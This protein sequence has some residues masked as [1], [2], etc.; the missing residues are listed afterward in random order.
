MTSYHGSRLAV[1]AII[2]A[3][4]A[5]VAT[6]ASPAYGAGRAYF[7]TT[8]ADDTVPDGFCTLREAM[9]AANNAPA[10]AD[11]GPGSLG[12]PD[13]IHFSEVGGT[14]VLGAPLPTITESLFIGGPKGVTLDGNARVHPFMINPSVDVTLERLTI[15]NGKA[16]DG[17]STN[18][19]LGE[20]GGAIHNRGALRLTDVRITHSAAGHGGS[21]LDG[22]A[23]G[24][25]GGAIYNAGTIVGYRVTFD[26]N[27]AGNGGPTVRVV[28]R[29]GHGGAI[30]NDEGGSVT[31]Y[32][33][34]FTGNAPGTSVVPGRILGFD[35]NGS[36]L[37]SRG[38]AII[39]AS[40][41]WANVNLGTGVIVPG[42]NGSVLVSSTI[43]SDHDTCQVPFGGVI[44]NG[45]FNIENTGVHCFS[46]LGAGQ[47]PLVETELRINGGFVPTLAPRGIPPI[48]GVPFSFE[49][50]A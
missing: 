2:I 28:N 49:D 17:P 9:L 6:I 24:G 26:N 34:T 40:T 18:S 25:N 42:P 14:I 5:V 46:L 12:G 4:Q 22:G 39:K 19:L 37:F 20:D 21:D 13:F 38:S 33:A 11:C 8:L 44:Q 43:L 7:V 1:V 15:T 23:L 30:F 48:D 3:M 27:S 31:L 32:D 10:N 45:G 47:T 16:P 50:C 35:G 36:V 29:G 41:F